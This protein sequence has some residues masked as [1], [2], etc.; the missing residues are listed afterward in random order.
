MVAAC[1]VHTVLEAGHLL[2]GEFSFESQRCIYVAITYA[3]VHDSNFIQ[4]DPKGLQARAG[5]FIIA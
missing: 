3:S 1:L 2:G 4:I 5:Q